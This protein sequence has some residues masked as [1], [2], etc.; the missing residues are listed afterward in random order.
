MSVSSSFDNAYSSMYSLWQS[1]PTEITLAS[2]T[3]MVGLALAFG[4]REIFL[5]KDMKYV[6]EYIPRKREK[7][8]RRARTE[9][10]AALSADN[11]IQG[12]QK[13]VWEEIITQYECNQEYRKISNYLKNHNI[14]PKAIQLKN[15]INKR[16]EKKKLH[17]PKEKKYVANVASSSNVIR[18][19]VFGDKSIRHQQKKSA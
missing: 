14:M 8:L 12:M 9:F 5:A 2:F 16:L 10:V 18:R 19:N 17:P 4:V 6:Q 13:L 1:Y 15:E 3:V 7:M 11:Y